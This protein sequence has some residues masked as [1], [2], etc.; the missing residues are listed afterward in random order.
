MARMR[1]TKNDLKESVRKKLIKILN[2][3]LVDSIH[4]SIQAKQAHWNVRGPGFFMFHELFDKFYET[5]T[6][7]TDMLAERCVQL[8][9]VAE[10]NLDSVSR[11]TR[12]SNYS[13]D[14]VEGPKHVQALLMSL[15]HFCRT[16]REATDACTSGGDAGSADV[17]TEISRAADKFMWIFEAHFVEMK[18]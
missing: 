11:R 4:L 6:G 15:S 10:G 12:I 17:F 2:E 18:R 7:W 13:L 16:V 1:V 14:L 8:G 5:T 3:N 9:G